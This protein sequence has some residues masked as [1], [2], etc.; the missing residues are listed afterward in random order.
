M[1]EN[2]A[3]EAIKLEGGLEIKGNPARLVKLFE[4]LEVADKAL[5]EIQKYRNKRLIDAD[6]LI[7][8]RVENDPVVISVK[9][10]LAAYNLDEA[11]ERCEEELMEYRK[12]SNRLKSIYGDQM[13]LKDMVDVMENI[14]RDPD[15]KHPIYARILSCGEAAMWDEYRKLGTP[16]DL[17]EMMENGS[18]TGIELAQIAAIQMKLKKYEDIGT[19]EECRA[20]VEKS[21]KIAVLLKREEE[22]E[23][24]RAVMKQIAELVIPQITKE[25]VNDGRQSNSGTVFKSVEHSTEQTGTIRRRRR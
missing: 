6:E 18:F 17:R 5:E 10:A 13:T 2:E 11:M 24:S 15:W 19:V 22:R 14:L 7:K 23:E 21:R 20:A 4:G 8:G 16:E 1:T 9:C 12:L 3:R 25:G